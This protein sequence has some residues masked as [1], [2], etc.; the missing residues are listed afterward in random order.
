MFFK[1]N[2]N[3]PSFEK[4][5]E[6]VRD[7]FEDM[8]YD[9]ESLNEQ[10][11]LIY[12]TIRDSEEWNHIDAKDVFVLAHNSTIQTACNPF[13]PAIH[14]QNYEGRHHTFSRN[15]KRMCDCETEMCDC[16]STITYI[17]DDVRF[18][19]DPS[20]YDDR[21]QS[22]LEHL[23]S[24][25]SEDWRTINNVDAYGNTALIIACQSPIPSSLIVELLLN[26]GAD[27]FYENKNGDD[28][29]DTA[30]QS[31]NIPILTVLIK[32]LQLYPNR[33]LMEKIVA[34]IRD[35]PNR[36]LWEMFI[37]ACVI[38]D[39]EIAALSLANKLRSAPELF[40]E[41]MKWTDEETA[42]QIIYGARPASATSY[43]KDI[44]AAQI[45]TLL[46]AHSEGSHEVEPNS[47]LFTNHENK[48]IGRFFSITQQLPLELQSRLANIIAI[49]HPAPMSTLFIPSEESSIHPSDI[50]SCNRIEE[51]I[52][53]L[54]I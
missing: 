26:K 18:A 52:A 19:I 36:K 27:V 53:V 9:L 47:K 13:Y 17:E 44:L 35:H 16:G 33:V 34:K 30:L 29:I 11:F 50:I 14:R 2:K 46:A 15:K 21:I 54:S 38:F 3:F 24:L 22:Q 41:M 4:D 39:P 31:S 25:S 45:L 32:H 48:C 20:E 6:E 42:N 10:Q 7:N 8:E 1:K 49:Q 37:G 28:V 43:K 12:E 5:Y 51:A 23:N 40:N